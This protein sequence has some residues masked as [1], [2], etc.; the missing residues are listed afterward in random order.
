MDCEKRERY[1]ELALEV[2]QIQITQREIEE[3]EK[4]KST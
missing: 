3:S 2:Y 4:D 1:N